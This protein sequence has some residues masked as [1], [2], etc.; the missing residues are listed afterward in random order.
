MSKIQLQLE[1]GAADPSGMNLQQSSGRR[2]TRTRSMTLASAEARVMLRTA[3]GPYCQA[4]YQQ[5]RD[6]AGHS[7]TFETIGPSGATYRVDC[8]VNQVS[9]DDEMVTVAGIAT[10]IGSGTWQ[11]DETSLGF[12]VLSDG[13]IF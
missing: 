6:M 13:T 8:F 9:P 4:G 2:S 10:E 3:L 7:T 12:S 5:L 1:S 11:Q